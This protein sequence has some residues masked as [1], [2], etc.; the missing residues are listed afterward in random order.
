C[1]PGRRSSRPPRGRARGTLGRA[2]R[3]RYPNVEILASGAAMT[4]KALEE[5]VAASTRLSDVD[6]RTGRLWYVGYDIH[7]LATRST[8]E[9]VVYLLHN[10]RLPTEA[11]LE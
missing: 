11:E 2:C 5:V 9:E 4:D 10:L 7:E 8:V 6:G 1:Q 3:S